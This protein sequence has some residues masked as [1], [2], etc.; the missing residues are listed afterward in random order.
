MQPDLII[1]G[2]TVV[3]DSGERQADVM[4]SNGAVVDVGTGLDAPS[5]ATE[6]DARDCWVSPGLVDLRC[7]TR[8]PGWEE[9]ET[10][11]TAARAAALGGFTTII[12]MP[13]TEPTID[14]A[15]MVSHIRTLAAGTLCTVAPAGAISVGCRGETLAPMAEMAD[16]GVR[17]FTDVTTVADDR[18]MRRAL[19]YAAGLDVTVAGLCESPALARGAHL[20]EGPVSSHIGIA[21]APGE[22]ESLIVARDI[23]LAR[24][25]NA[26]LHLSGLTTAAAVD[27][28]SAARAGGQNLTF[29]TTAHHLVLTDEACRGFDTS[30]KMRPHLRPAA[31]RAALRTALA[32][33]VLDAVASAHSPATIDDKVRPFDE[34]GFGALGLQTTLSLLLTLRAAGDL[35]LSPSELIAAVST[36]PARIAGLDHH[37]TTVAAGQQADLVVI[38]PGASWTVDADR[39]ASRS[40]NTPHDGK[41]LTGSIRHTINNGEAVVRNG[42]ATR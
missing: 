9:A 15:A 19:D 31:D 2:G 24:M 20:H 23:A 8:E 39:L 28:V 1:R 10:V 4:V 13:D 33:G 12:A 3:D 6:L 41:N 37:P 30:T 11:E 17:L 29:D 27:A 40:R 16:A 22:C 7:H 34:A 42:E 21:G 18:L 26:R 35:E 38:D 36:R 14:T 32:T 5:D 25:S